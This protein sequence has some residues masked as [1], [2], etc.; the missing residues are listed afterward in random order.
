MQPSLEDLQNWARQAGALIRAGYE[1]DHEIHM[2]GEID[3]VTEM[4]RRAE[5]F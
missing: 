5:D 4:D 1:Q 3:L 2:K